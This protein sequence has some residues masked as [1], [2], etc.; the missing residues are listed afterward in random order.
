MLLQKESA[1]DRKAKAIASLASPVPHGRAWI[2][3]FNVAVLLFICAV[4]FHN[5]AAGTG[6]QNAGDKEPKSSSA[7]PDLSL[8][9]DR[10]LLSVTNIDSE[11]EFYRDKLGFTQ[12]QHIVYGPEREVWQMTIP[13][14][15][16]DIVRA[17]G[18][19]PYKIASPRYMQQG[20]VHI[21]FS[22]PNLSAAFDF[23]KSAGTDVIAN[24]DEHQGITRLLVHDPEGNEIEIFPRL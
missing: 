3:L 23:L 18:S 2:L 1:Q 11:R 16:M 5:V 12:G 10:I 19:Q 15:R 17:T 6:T 14:Y 9:A 8:R 22:A 21:A 7:A 24:R 20:W 13:G 4:A